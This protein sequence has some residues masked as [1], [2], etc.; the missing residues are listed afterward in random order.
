MDCNATVHD[1]ACS[2]CG[3]ETLEDD[4]LCDRCSYRVPLVAIALGS[5]L[6]VVLACWVLL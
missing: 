2:K 4:G 1:Y 5:I 3:D 6:G